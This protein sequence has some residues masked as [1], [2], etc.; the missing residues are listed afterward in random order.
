MKIVV[1]V[2]SQ[3][4]RTA[5]MADASVADDAFRLYAG[6]KAARPSCSRVFAII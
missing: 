2:A 1:V 5:K 4:G 3:T 6:C